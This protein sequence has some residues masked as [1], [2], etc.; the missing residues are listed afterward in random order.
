VESSCLDT[1]P[2]LTYADLADALRLTNDTAQVVGGTALR[3]TTTL[4]SP[5]PVQSRA[6]PSS[7]FRNA[8]VVLTSLETRVPK[9][10][11]WA[12]AFQE[13]FGV[14]CEI[15][16]YITPAGSQGLPLHNEKSDVFAAQIFGEKFWSVWDLSEDN[17]SRVSLP[18]G[19]GSIALVHAPFQAHIVSLATS[20][21]PTVDEESTT[22][23]TTAAST[24]ETW[25]VSTPDIA[26][27]EAGED[28][29][30]KSLGVAPSLTTR[31]GE[32]SLLYVPRGSLHVAST[33]SLQL[34]T[35]VHLAISTSTQGFS[36]A[37]LIY[38]L[39]AEP[40]VQSAIDGLQWSVPKFRQT[41][42]RLTDQAQDGV[43][44]RRSLP[45]GWVRREAGSGS[46]AC[47]PA[48]GS[49]FSF[50]GPATPAAAS[51]DQVQ[52]NLETLLH[53]VLQDAPGSKDAKLSTSPP[54]Q[55]QRETSRAAALVLSNQ[56]KNAD[57][58]L[59]AVE[60][61]SVAHG[62]NTIQLP[63]GL[64]VDYVAWDVD[65]FG[66]GEMLVRFSWCRR[67]AKGAVKARWSAAMLPMLQ[68]VAE[69]RS[70]R[71]SLT[72]FGSNSDLVPQL[73]FAL[74]LEGLPLDPPIRLVVDDIDTS[75]TSTTAGMA[76]AQAWQ[77]DP[78]C[79]DEVAGDL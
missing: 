26:L 52:A 78:D 15:S 41:L 62:G 50:S 4:L 1:T 49:W 30:Q 39:A 31:L 19:A 7:F 77:R 38:H 60:H 70:R 72:E 20:K 24:V 5:Q 36:Y 18:S 33:A 63:V 54:F 9:L 3:Q 61:G 73:L 12:R 42:M 8:T 35:S 44:F 10:A 25:G 55:L 16:M 17:K 40:A 23:S 11:K 71:I 57:S 53:R 56:L 51:D 34:G 45:L 14:L 76:G 28:D 79:E 22:A 46:W 27:F 65:D 43:A 21:I 66:G 32:G 59:A 47:A 13:A 48:P 2:L 37:V 69:S 68:K 75:T 67:G 6:S 29:V 64:Y 74:E 58:S